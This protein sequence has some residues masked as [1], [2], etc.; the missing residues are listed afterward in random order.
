MLEILSYIIA[1]CAVAYVVLPLL[2]KDFRFVPTGQQKSNKLTNLVHQRTL[3][4]E[5]K[6]DLEFDFQ[7]G[8]LDKEDFDSL[9][10]EQDGHLEKI[11][12]RIHQAAGIST[13]DIDQ[14]LEQEISQQRK[15]LQPELLPGCN[16][17]G[18]AIAPGD[19]FCSKCGTKI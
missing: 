1:L 7:T 18:H 17:C 13:K 19:K 11:E 9:S 16:S 12:K 3:V 2:K 14:K 5:T 4:Q 10:E 15:K 8:K 6:N